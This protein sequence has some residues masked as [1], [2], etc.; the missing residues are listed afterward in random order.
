MKGRMDMYKYLV[1]L[2]CGVSTK[3]ESKYLSPSVIE[4]MLNQHNP[5]V[6]IGEDVFSKD[7][8]AMI[9]LMKDESEELTTMKK[10]IFE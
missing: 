1:T 5:F 6:Q 2:N 9:Q 4:S 8:V 7:S 10:E 3:A